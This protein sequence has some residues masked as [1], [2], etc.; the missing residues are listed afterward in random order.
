MQHSTISLFHLFIISW[1]VKSLCFANKYNSTS[2]ASLFL[3]SLSVSLLG[4]WYTLLFL[5][6]Q[7]FLEQISHIPHCLITNI[8]V[9]IN[10]W[11]SCERNNVKLFLFQCS[12]FTLNVHRTLFNAHTKCS[13]PVNFPIF[14]F[15]GSLEPAW[16]DF[17]KNCKTVILEFFLVESGKFKLYAIANVW[18]TC[19]S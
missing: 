19:Q 15:H 12:M 7:W 6:L 8:I 18:W 11:H 1:I 16:Q 3:S 14:P 13:P 10:Y 5:K 2:R 17:L 4:C 9:K